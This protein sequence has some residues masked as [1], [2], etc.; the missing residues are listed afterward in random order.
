[1]GI[2][3]SL[4]TI[5]R[6]LLYSVHIYAFIMASDPFATS[7]P[8]QDR[9]REDDDYPLT[10][11][12]ESHEELSSADHEAA[13]FASITQGPRNPITAAIR[14][15]GIQMNA[16]RR[17]VTIGAHIRGAATAWLDMDDSGNYDPK[18]ER[19]KPRRKPPKKRRSSFVIDEDDS[20]DD[21][22]GTPRKIRKPVGYSLPIT[23]TLTSKKGLAYLRSITPGLESSQ[24]SLT[25]DEI[26][27]SDDDSSTESLNHR[28]NVKTPKQLGQAITRFVLLLDS[29]TCT[30]DNQE[31]TA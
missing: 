31:P 16:R 20:E 11:H 22:H 3:N 5:A 8:P 23:L 19:A 1:M 14:N 9:P 12:R 18:Q 10:E 6:A 27:D 21:D 29:I 24:S 15:L 30:D 13:Y 7:P 4:S 17:K 26:L 2:L 28:R 25:G